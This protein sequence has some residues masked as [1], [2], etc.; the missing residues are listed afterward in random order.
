M[1]LINEKI[2]ILDIPQ[3]FESFGLERCL[4]SLK[5]SLMRI[6]KGKFL[7]CLIKFIEQS[8]G[9]AFGFPCCVS[10]YVHRQFYIIVS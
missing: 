2:K 4:L 9:I 3:Y 7:L 10:I 5:I 8:C 6:F 1:F